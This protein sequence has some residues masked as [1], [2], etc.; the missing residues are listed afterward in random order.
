MI[1]NIGGRPDPAAMMPEFSF[2]GRYDLINDGV[3]DG[4]QNWRIRLYES[5]S[6]TFNRTAQEAEVFLVGGGGGGAAGGGG[7]AGGYTRMGSIALEPNPTYHVTVGSGGM[8]SAKMIPDAPCVRDEKLITG[9]SA[10][11]AIP[12]GLMLID[13]LKGEAAAKAV[14][15][16][17][18]IR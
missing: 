7:G 3:K 6:L 2:S 17:I 11:C 13:A 16:Q 12:F 9:T 1:F 4:V 10:G 18:V 8:G 5:G 15:D 14:K